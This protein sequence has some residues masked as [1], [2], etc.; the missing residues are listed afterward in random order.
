MMSILCLAADVVYLGNKFTVFK[1][2]ML[3]VA[4]LKNLDN[5]GLD[6]SSVA[7]FSNIGTRAPTMAEC[8]P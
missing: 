8:S 3:N 2:L 6:L 5:F 7:D 1:V 4:M